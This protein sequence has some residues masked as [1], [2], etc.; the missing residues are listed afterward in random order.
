[1]IVLKPLNQLCDK[2]SSFSD[3][4]Q[5][6]DDGYL[7]RARE[8][9]RIVRLKSGYYRSGTQYG[10]QQVRSRFGT[11]RQHTVKVHRAVALAFVPRP[12]NANDVDHINNVKTDNR[13]ENLQWL[14][15]RENIIKRFRQASQ[16][17]GFGTLCCGA[18]M[19]ENENLVVPAIIILI[20]VAMIIKGK[21][22]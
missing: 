16:Y 6:G 3:E 15:H 12:F 5:V 14:T 22:E 17:C 7:Y 18:M 2:W 8:D 20:G 10:Y 4:Y 9:G 19:G 1:M 21:D 13:A 11:D